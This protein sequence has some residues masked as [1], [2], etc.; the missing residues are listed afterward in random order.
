MQDH[1][2]M[3]M[4]V[5]LSP[6][7]VMGGDWK[8]PIPPKSCCN[9]DIKNIVP[10]IKTFLYWQPIYDFKAMFLNNLF[11]KTLFLV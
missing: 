11:Y 3:F 5:L 8:L 4:H 9:V 10:P 2:T 1:F 6:T 7:K